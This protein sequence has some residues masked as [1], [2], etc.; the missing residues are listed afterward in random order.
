MRTTDREIFVAVAVAPQK[1]PK[2]LALSQVIAKRRG[3]PYIT[4]M[5]E[6][7]PASRRSV[8]VN[9]PSV[10][11]GVPSDTHHLGGHILFLSAANL[12]QPY[13]TAQK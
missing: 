1:W 4:A 12:L 10:R 9:P 3:I 13:S 11:E 2:G 5:S 6:T 7:R 8:L